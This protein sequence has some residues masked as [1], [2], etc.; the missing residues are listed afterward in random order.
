MVRLKPFYSNDFR[1]DHYMVVMLR[2]LE[3]NHIM[4]THHEVNKTNYITFILFLR[5]N[6]ITFTIQAYYFYDAII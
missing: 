2:W 1:D 3:L 5:Y 6:Q 4:V